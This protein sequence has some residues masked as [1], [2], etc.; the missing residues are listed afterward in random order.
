MSAV[1]APSVIVTFVLPANGFVQ[2]AA[3]GVQTPSSVAYT[4]DRKKR[5]PVGPKASTSV[6]YA[7]LPLM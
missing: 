5:L 4:N 1:H 7:S 6:R 2:S 3:S